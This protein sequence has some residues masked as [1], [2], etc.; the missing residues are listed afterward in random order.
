MSI[1]QALAMTVAEIP[2]F[3]YSTFGQ[4]N[5]FK[6]RPIIYIVMCNLM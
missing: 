6:H 4:V 3:L 2:V 1:A 5:L